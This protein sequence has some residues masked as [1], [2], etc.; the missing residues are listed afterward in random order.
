MTYPTDNSYN[1]RGLDGILARCLAYTVFSGISGETEYTEK[2]NWV[3]L[4]SSTRFSTLNEGTVDVV[5]RN[6]SKTFSREVED[7][8]RFGPTIFFDGQKM[9]FL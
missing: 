7:G 1:F 5:F 9:I 3:G 2:V 8:F 4:N 6:T